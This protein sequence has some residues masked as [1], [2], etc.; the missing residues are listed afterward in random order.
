M[1]SISDQ[2]SAV[3]K[4]QFDAQFDFFNAIASQTLE[5]A[6]RVAALN[7]AVSR[8]AVQRSLGAS[9]AL[10]N[11]RDPRDVLSLGGQA[12]EGFR[13][14]F[15]YG[16]EL[17]GI[18][19]GVRPYAVRPQGLSA[20]QAIETVEVVESGVAEVQPASVAAVESVVEAAVEAA[21]AVEAAHP[22]AAFAPV[23]EP[24][25]VAEPA[26]APEA[27]AETLAAEPVPV[28]EPKAIAKAV[29]KGAARAAAVPHP[30]A[31]PVAELAT[32]EG[33]EAPK[34]VPA[35]AVSKRKK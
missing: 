1:T 20:P 30:A 32:D 18:A 11:S 14:L 15:S 25:V 27:V 33:A 26:A 6:S 24:V 12:E 23:S 28:A 13:S 29:G 5:S 31:A 10:L 4:A 34:L 22:V 17:F 19:A 7:M 16:R 9:F 2:F 21:P 35:P 3:R 8:D